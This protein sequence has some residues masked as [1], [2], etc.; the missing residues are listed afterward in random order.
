MFEISW[1][2]F[3]VISLTSLLSSKKCSSEESEEPPLTDLWVA[4]AK[5]ICWSR[6]SSLCTLQMDK[7]TVFVGTHSTTQGVFAIV[8]M[9]MTKISY[10]IFKD[11]IFIFLKM[12]SFVILSHCIIV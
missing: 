8:V 2:K 5:Q 4:R 1:L 6:F 10:K 7:C 3:D 12:V 11:L 9:L